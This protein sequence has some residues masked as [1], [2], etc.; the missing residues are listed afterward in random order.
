MLKV[1]YP[2]VEMKLSYTLVVCM[3]WIYDSEQCAIKSCSS[4]SVDVEILIF[5]YRCADLGWWLL[6]KCYM[7]HR[8]L[9]DYDFELFFCCKVNL[10]HRK[11][12]SRSSK[13]EQLFQLFIVHKRL[14][15]AYS[16]LPRI[17]SNTSQFSMVQ[18]TISAFTLAFFLI[19]NLPKIVDD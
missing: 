13:K 17:T 19:R 10:I 16:E 9:N 18:V 15:C 2:G 6:Q 5:H 7:N 11:H 3:L 4:S 8:D 1:F 12:S 14:F